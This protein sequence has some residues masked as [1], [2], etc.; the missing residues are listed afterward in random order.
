MNNPHD[1]AAEDAAADEMLSELLLPF[2]SAKP[3][4]QVKSANRAAIAKALANASRLTWWRRTVSVPLPLAV[5][6]GVAIVAAAIGLLVPRSG[7]S[8]VRHEEPLRIQTWDQT[9]PAS[10][11]PH[12]TAADSGSDGW[13][14]S[15]SYLGSL[16]SLT[17]VFNPLDENDK[18]QRD[19]S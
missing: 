9:Y 12:F 2:R 4:A 7:N 11:L 5:A 18:E 6:A 17:A 14:V 15:R 13:T 1:D 3:S 10:L 8:L 19:D 16:E